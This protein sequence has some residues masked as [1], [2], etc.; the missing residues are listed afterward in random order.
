MRARPR[1][2]AKAVLF[3]LPWLPSLGAPD[4]ARAGPALD[5]AVSAAGL[6]PSDPLPLK[7]EK[8]LRLLNDRGYLGRTPEPGTLPPP[9]DLPYN[10]DSLRTPEEI[11]SEKRGGYCNSKALAAAA[12]LVQAG[13]PE[14]DVRVVEAVNDE[15][16]AVICPRRGEPRAEDPPTGA[17]G[18]VFVAVRWTN[19]RWRLVNTVDSAKDYGWAPWHEPGRVAKL[20]R[21]KPLAVP[22]RAT[23]G[24]PYTPMTVVQSWRLSDV[25]RNDFEQHLDISASGVIGLKTCRYGPPRRKRD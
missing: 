19:G 2:F 18:H 23:R 16:L 20:M 13:V 25:P 3:V 5:P 6:A 8:V 22:A 10:L 24:G 14:D 4:H 9:F 12:L 7:V 1:L 11:L 15:D 17:S 21:G